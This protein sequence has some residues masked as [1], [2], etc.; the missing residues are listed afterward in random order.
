V[1][2]SLKK[3]DINTRIFTL[4]RTLFLEAL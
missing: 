2:I 1:R 3:D 4:I